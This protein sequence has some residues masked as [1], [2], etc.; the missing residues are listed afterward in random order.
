[1]D[2]L[3]INSQ[4][5]S[6]TLV[7]PAYLQLSSRFQLVSLLVMA[8]LNHHSPHSHRYF[9]NKKKGF[10]IKFVT[11]LAQLRKH[12]VEFFFPLQVAKKRIS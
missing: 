5:S 3:P 9:V 7:G 1:M 11:Q 10:N 2:I 4:E 8:V 6:C 12:Q